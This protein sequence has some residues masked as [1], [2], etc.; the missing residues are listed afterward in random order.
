M[1]HRAR[2]R[3]LFHM[4]KLDSLFSNPMKLQRDAEEQGGLVIAPGINGELE[5]VPIKA[6]HFVPR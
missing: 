4:N 2:P 3:R 6:D 5:L 1:R